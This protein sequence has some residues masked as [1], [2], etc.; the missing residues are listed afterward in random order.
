MT[1]AIA[2][3]ETIPCIGHTTAVAIIA[4][5]ETD[6]CRFPSAKYLASWAGGCPGNRQSV[7]KRLGGRTTKGHPWLRAALGEVTWSM[8]H[9]LNSYLAAQYHRFARRIGKH[10]ASVAVSHS[11][12]VIIYHMLATQHS[13]SD[14]GPG[15]F[16]SLENERLQRHYIRRLEQLGFAVT[17]TSP[18]TT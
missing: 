3:L 7:G 14:L 17:L 15:Y 2:L 12:F 11:L 18:Q 8:A 6:M 10:K 16:D 9:T 1:N 5:I 13:Y 4:E